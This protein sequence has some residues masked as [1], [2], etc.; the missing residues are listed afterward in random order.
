MR[1][2]EGRQEAEAGW[3]A[4]DADYIVNVVAAGR[5]G[6]SPKLVVMLPGG[7]GAAPAHEARGSEEALGRRHRG[8]RVSSA[9]RSRP[10]DAFQGEY[11]REAGGESGQRCA[12]VGSPSHAH[13]ENGIHMDAGPGF[14][15]LCATTCPGGLPLWHE[16][17]LPGS[18]WAKA[19][20]CREP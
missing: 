4:A 8:R 2:T 3:T 20:L 16:L 17:W 1:R 19:W 15:D 9:D 10:A 12:R 13:L 18:G 6:P 14:Q 5:V 7:I 11:G